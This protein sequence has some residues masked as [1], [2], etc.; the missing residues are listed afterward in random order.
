MNCARAARFQLALMHTTPQ[1]WRGWGP[2]E[3][4]LTLSKKSPE[5]AHPQYLFPGNCFPSR[6]SAGNQRLHSQSSLHAGRPESYFA[7]FVCVSYALVEGHF[8]LS[9]LRARPHRATKKEADLPNIASW[10]HPGNILYR[11]DVNI[12]S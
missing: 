5:G 1:I 3:L 4:L 8:P 10:D 9:S 6:D 7:R 2:F 12:L 11:R